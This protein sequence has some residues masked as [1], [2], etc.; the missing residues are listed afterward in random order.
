VEDSKAREETVLDEKT[1]LD[2]ETV[3]HEKTV[4]EARA[5]TKRFGD[6]LAVDRVF[7]RVQAGTVCGLLGRNGAGKTTLLRMILGLMTPDSGTVSLLGHQVAPGDVAAMAAVAGF[8]EEPRFYPY[9]SAQRNLELLARLD[10]PQATVTPEHA[11]ELVELA[12]R[13]RDKAGTFSR[14]MRQR[15]GLAAALMRSPRLMVLDE[16]TIGLDPAGAAA[17]RQLLR[18]LACD[19]AAVLV[20]SHN[21][22]EVAEICDQ[23]LIIHEGR[24]VW[25]GSRADLDRA[26]PVPA[27]RMWTSDDGRAADLARRL[28]LRAEA[29][30]PAGSGAPLTIHAGDEDRD[31][32]V[33]KLAGTGVAVRRLEPD[34]PQLEALFTSLTGTQAGPGAVPEAGVIA[35]ASSVTEAAI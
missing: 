15:L 11:L 33:L 31:A 6:R 18:N 14:G 2:E 1:V 24:S 20:S 28:Q 32:F 30:G 26:A 29:G 10:G 12:D 35:D 21:M 7:L 9:L 19:G 16:P 8:V 4:L 17:L 13:G 3:L 23:V 22:A 5:L 27:W 34:V 25:Q